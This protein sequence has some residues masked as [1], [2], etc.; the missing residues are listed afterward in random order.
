MKVGWNLTFKHEKEH[1]RSL[2]SPVCTCLCTY[3]QTKD[4][5]VITQIC[6]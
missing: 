2:V 5:D 4:G 1:H 3:T 6:L